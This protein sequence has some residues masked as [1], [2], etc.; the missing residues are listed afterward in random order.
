MSKSNYLDTSSYFNIIDNPDVSEF[1]CDCN[2]LSEPTEEQLDEIKR[3]FN[4][5]K[6]NDDCLPENII[7][8]DSDLHETAIRKEL[9]YTNVGYVKIVGNLLKKADYI[10][11]DG[12]HFVDPFQV[13]KV[14]KSKEEMLLILP[15]SNMS[16]KGK[17]TAKD[18]FR[19]ALE[20]FFEKISSKDGGEIT[21]LKET[22]F[23]LASYRDNGSS[24]EKII[25]HKCSNCG[26]P[27]IE[28]LNIKEKQKCPYCG[29]DIYATDVLRIY[30]AVEEMSLSN[31]GALGR[32]KVVMKHI[33]LAHLLRTLIEFN[34][35]IYVNIFDELAFVIN[36]TLAI[37]GQPAWIHNCLMKII[38]DINS[39]MR[40]NNKRDILILGIVSEGANIK[41]FTNMVS[42][43][44]DN[45]SLYCVSDDF[46][47]NYIECNRSPSSTTFGAETYYGQDFIYKSRKGKSF[48]FNLPYPF[49]SKE[50]LKV[51][52]EGKSNISYYNNLDKAINVI[53][54]FECDLSSEKIV[55]IILSEKYTSISI[56]PGATVLDLLTK[57]SL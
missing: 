49:R 41:T 16:Y 1:L 46:R 9:P 42:Q 14:T 37:S 47:N 28:V 25:L 11:L 6:V 2:Y 27:D 8:I 33:Y 10:K 53:N 45:G 22:L 40:K 5:Y 31:V 20:E 17:N 57:N 56:E 38:S 43:Y 35:D 30:E 24:R 12:N 48:V 23:W 4:L 26:H 18:S 51:F 29:A 36:G 39:S 52:K 15:C 7:A 34:K 32:L 54:E 44:V 3:V 19:L 50:S 55:P 13:A 21:S